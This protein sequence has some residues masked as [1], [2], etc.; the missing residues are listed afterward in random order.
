M[1]LGFIKGL[2]FKHVLQG[3]SIKLGREPNW[4]G[5]LTTLTIKF[6]RAVYFFM[7]IC[8]YV[9][10]RTTIELPDE[11]YK[12][13]KIKAVEENL[14]LKDLVT[15]GLQNELASFAGVCEPHA[16]Y[17]S[18]RKMAPDYVRQKLNGELRGGT[19]ST[20]IISEDRSSREDPI[21]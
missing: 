9:F 19:D 11:L 8:L 3:G 5:N 6:K 18:Q 2:S 12:A 1:G 13:A 15:R 20:K 21:S 7:I 4:T 17:W 16:P 14:S 10:M